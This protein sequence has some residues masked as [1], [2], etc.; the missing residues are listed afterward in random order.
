MITKPEKYTRKFVVKE[1]K[2]LLMKARNEDLLIMGELFENKQY[3]A[4]RFSEWAEKFEKEVEISESIKKIKE[5]FE[6]RI[7]KGALTGKLNPTMTIFNLKNNYGWKDKTD[8]DH[9]TKGKELPVPILG[10]ISR[11]V[12][13]RLR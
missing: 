12:N 10:G 13:L 1:L 5:L 9:T 7:N 6:N 4:Q 11:G 2:N 8:I 3:S